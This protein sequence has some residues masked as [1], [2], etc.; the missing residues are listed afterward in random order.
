MQLPRELET[1]GY[2]LL[3]LP[4]T[5]STNDDAAHAAREGDPGRLWIVAQAQRQGR[6]RQGR[7]WSSPPG[8]LYTSLLLIEPCKPARAPQ[9]GF[10]AGL[11]LHEA[12][13]R[14]TGLAAPRLALKWPN[15]LL[16]EGAKVAG[17]LLEAQSAPAF[18]VVIGFG[19]NVAFHPSDTP[20]RSAALTD[21]APGASAP[22]LFGALANAFARRLGTWQNAL[23]DD[24]PDAFRPVLDEWLSC[25]AGLGS[26]IRLRLPTGEREG[27]FAGLDPTGRLQ[28]QT[29]AGLELIDAGDLYFPALQTDA[30][31]AA[32]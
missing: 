17:I 32:R 24:E 11:A 20:Y 6:G 14:V 9:L 12:I 8:N 10:L 7:A 3:S 18:S 5:L 29:C 28:L 31:L 15:D 13:S 26:V 21:F 23:R 27:R 22:A 2:R 30:A 4:E 25:A 19:V 16:V 1:A